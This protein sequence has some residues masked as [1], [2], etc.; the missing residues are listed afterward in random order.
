MKLQNGERVDGIEKDPLDSAE[1]DYQYDYNMV[2]GFL[3]REE[4][5]AGESKPILHPHDKSLAYVNKMLKK[6]RDLHES[7]KI[8][9]EVEEEAKEDVQ[10]S[11]IVNLTESQLESAV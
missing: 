4:S 2:P 5:V 7:H 10:K 3:K 11:E 8:K 6:G 1:N 9:E